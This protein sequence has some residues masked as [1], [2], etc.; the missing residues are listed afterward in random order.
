MKSLFIINSHVPNPNRPNCTDKWTR[1]TAIWQLLYTVGLEQHANLYYTTGLA[2]KYRV[3]RNIWTAQQKSPCLHKRKVLAGV[4]IT[5]NMGVTQWPTRSRVIDY[6]LCKNKILSLYT[7]QPD[8]YL[9]DTTIK[10]V[11][12]SCTRFDVN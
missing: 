3:H 12:T 1:N 7:R 10:S 9:Q 2:P 6:A 5:T 4:D 11:Q 8:Q